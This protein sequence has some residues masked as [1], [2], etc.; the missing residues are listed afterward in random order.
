MTLRGGGCQPALPYW[1]FAVDHLVNQGGLSSNQSRIFPAIVGV[2]SIPAGD[3][4]RL[5]NAM[6]LSSMGTMHGPGG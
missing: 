6:L 5:P 3:T 4:V 2:A 1:P